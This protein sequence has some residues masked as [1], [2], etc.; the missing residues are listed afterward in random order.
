MNSSAKYREQ[1]RALVAQMTLEEKA[2]QLTY[3]SPA[4]KRLALLN[5][6]ILIK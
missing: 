2:G 6:V 4:I 1:A 5:N 3:Q